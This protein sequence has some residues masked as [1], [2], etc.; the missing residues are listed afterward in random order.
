[1]K[2]WITRDKGS[3]YG[4]NRVYLWKTTD[5]PSKVI[6]DECVTY[7]DSDAIKNEKVVEMFVDEFEMVF[8]VKPK[9]G[10]CRRYSI[11]KIFKV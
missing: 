9:V 1:M 11:P 5:A 4:E 8:G 3:S 10:S 6:D 2:Y 7:Q